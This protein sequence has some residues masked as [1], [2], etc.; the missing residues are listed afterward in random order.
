VRGVNRCC[1]SSAVNGTDDY[2]LWNGITE[3]RNVPSVCVEH[4]STDCEDG[5]R[6]TEWYRWTESDMLCVL[7]V[8]F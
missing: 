7:S 2:M 1:I 6:D 8:S 5:D 4:E 3:V